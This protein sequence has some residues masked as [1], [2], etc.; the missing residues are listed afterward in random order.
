[1][2]VLLNFLSNNVLIIVAGLAGGFVGL[3]VS[4]KELGKIIR[5]LRTST[6]EIGSLPMDEQVEIVGSADGDASIHSPIT[7]QPCVL[8]Q[9]D[10]LELRRS[11]KHSR[12]VTIY[13]D[14]STTPFDVHDVTG[15]M[16]VYP[17]S[18]TELVLKD[19]TKQ[20]S[21]LFSSLDEQTQIMLG[22]L[23]IKT[24]GFLNLNKPLQVNERYIEKGDQIY[25]FGRAGI[26]NGTKAMDGNAPLM[27][28]DHSE[29][30]LLSR[31]IGQVVMNILIGVFFI[32]AI[33]LAV[34]D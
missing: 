17:G 5:M 2:D 22:E 14:R 18:Q 1:M 29:L 30:R 3:L 9:V 10:V 19:D 7:K 20:T 31:S 6:G 12:W 32:I 8:W 16:R 11:G 25:L 23:G 33:Y 4:Y 28:S 34:I 15:R 26:K 24:K 27:I 13:S 21:S